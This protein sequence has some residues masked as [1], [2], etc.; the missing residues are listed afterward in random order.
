MKRLSLVAVA[1]I[2]LVSP[3]QAGL[4][5]GMEAYDRGQCDTAFQELL[6]VAE[7]GHADAQ[8][9]VGEIYSDMSTSGAGGSERDAAKW[10]RLAAE[11]GHAGAQTRLAGMYLWRFHAVGGR[12]VTQAVSLYRSAADQGHPEAQARL[13]DLYARA[14]R[15]PKELT[16]ALLPK[17]PVE[18]AKW[19]RTAAEQ[20]S[21]SAQAELGRLYEEGEGVVRDFAEAISWYRKAA[22]QGSAKA[23][24]ALARMYEEGRGVAQNNAEAARWY[25]EARAFLDLGRIY[26]DG[27]G[28][29][30]DLVQAYTWFSLAY[31]WNEVAGKTAR[32]R[33][34]DQMTP[35]EIAKALALAQPQARK[36][37]PSDRRYRFSPSGGGIYPKYCLTGLPVPPEMRARWE[38]DRTR[39]EAGDL[40]SM[41]ALAGAYIK[42][43]VVPR[44]DAKAMT[45][46]RKACDR[47]AAPA[48]FSLGRMYLEGRGAA[49]DFVEAAK[50]F[51]IATSDTKLLKLARRNLKQASKLM[52]LADVKKAQGLA[53]AWRPDE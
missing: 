19:Y 16:P 3:V 50:W 6:P 24:R 17:N 38:R 9:Y 43:W 5:Q 46:V 35:A 11:Q 32:D 49:V 1:W 45:W 31:L 53:R 47:G 25:A 28:V 21:V 7:Q 39:A 29:P 4:D 30:R 36:R 26:R 37:R 51:I 41:S 22:E 14:R 27:R 10:Y 42:G 18:A 34:A 20:G 44:N 48:C 23:Q 33:I 13:A 15:F 2:G 8:F 40:V 12:D 52:T